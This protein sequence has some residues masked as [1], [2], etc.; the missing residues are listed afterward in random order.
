MS[1][2]AAAVMV[3]C[4]SQSPVRVNGKLIDKPESVEGIVTTQWQQGTIASWRIAPSDKIYVCLNKKCE[5]PAI[6]SIQKLI[7]RHGF[8]TTMNKEEANYTLYMRAFV[9]AERSSN[10][11]Q[12]VAMPV[13]AYHYLDDE[14]TAQMLLK[15]W[16]RKEDDWKSMNAYGKTTFW[17]LTAEIPITVYSHNNHK[18]GQITQ[19]IGGGS[20]AAYVLG[21]SIG[22][23][24]EAIYNKRAADDWRENLREG[25]VGI[26]MSFLTAKPSFLGGNTIRIV[27]S[28]AAS[29]KEERV[30]DLID[31]ALD[32]VVKNSGFIESIS[33][34]NSRP[35]AAPQG[36]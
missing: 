36:T 2:V 18:L 33:Q 28:F 7:Q 3:G 10:D 32:D 17:A 27:Y 12:R 35:Q 15:P 1:I 26:E 16:I 34:K 8:N 22:P 30:V 19:T 11:G 31:A 9:T 5:E 24:L 21:A 29:S 4:A 25:M 20:T 14:E 23:I 13:W 6:P